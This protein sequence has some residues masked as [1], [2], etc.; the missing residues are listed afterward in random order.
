MVLVASAALQA[1]TLYFTSSEIS[2]ALHWVKMLRRD[3]E[4]PVRIKLRPRV[5]G[6]LSDRTL[7]GDAA[8]CDLPS[9]IRWDEAS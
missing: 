4:M 8:L 5:Y 7:K 3:E 6:H 1:Q 2:R 9:I